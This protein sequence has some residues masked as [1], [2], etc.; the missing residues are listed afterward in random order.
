MRGN[1]NAKL[2][3][4]RFYRSSKWDRKAPLHLDFCSRSL[5]S[6]SKVQ[7]KN[8]I[9]KIRKIIKQNKSLLAK[10]KLRT[11][12]KYPLPRKWGKN[13]EK[14]ALGDTF[15][16]VWVDSWDMRKTLLI[17]FRLTIKKSSKNWKI[18]NIS[19]HPKFN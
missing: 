7:L 19:N 8:Q 3:K 2:I 15:L 9:K 5:E 11:P 18:I 10:K 1:W 13:L 12:I 6:I 17:F 16:M 14:L 4:S